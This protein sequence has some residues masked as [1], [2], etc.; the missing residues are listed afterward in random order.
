[1]NSV[2]MTIVEFTKIGDWWLGGK[3]EEIERKWSKK[4]LLKL[5]CYN[6]SGGQF[7][8]NDFKK[9]KTSYPNTLLL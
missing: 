9:L 3:I 4:L 5:A 7:G 6:L 2:D 8:N 1:M